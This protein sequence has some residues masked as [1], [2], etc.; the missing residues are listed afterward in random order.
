M[1]ADEINGIDT[2]DRLLAADLLHDEALDRLDES[3]VSAP[4]CPHQ[5]L[6]LP[7]KTDTPLGRPAPGR[8][9]PTRIFTG[10]EL[11]AQAALRPR[12]GN[13]TPMGA[14]SGCFRPFALEWESYNNDGVAAG[15]GYAA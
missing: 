7:G 3:C 5:G 2:V 15:T 13:V 9:R 1:N 4:A 12:S 6:V 8:G 14:R 11:A 10:D